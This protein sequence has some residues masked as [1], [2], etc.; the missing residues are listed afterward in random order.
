MNNCPEPKDQEKIKQAKNEFGEEKE[1]QR[2]KPSNTNNP[3]DNDTRGTDP[4]GPES[5]ETTEL[6]ETSTTEMVSKEYIRQTIAN[7]TSMAS[8]SEAATMA[9]VMSAALLKD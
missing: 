6:V 1:R 7:I 5:S 4:D 3:Q 2:N 9:A 8:D